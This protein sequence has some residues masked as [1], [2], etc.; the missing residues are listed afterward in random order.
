MRVVPTGV[1]DPGRDAALGR[2]GLLRGIGQSGLL[3]HRQPVHVCAQQH[4]R[5]IAVAHHRNHARPAD[6]LGHLEA[7]I[8]HSR[9]QFRGSFVLF[10]AQFRIGME[11]A[12]ELHQARHVGCQIVAQRIGLR[13]RGDKHRQCRKAGGNRFGHDVGSPCDVKRISYWLAQYRGHHICKAPIGTV[14]ARNSGR[15]S[16]QDAASKTGLAKKRN[17]SRV[18]LTTD[19]SLPARPTIW[20]P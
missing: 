1:H 20:S 16:A 14:R 13:R 7:E 3:D 11:I 17:R 6:L 5:P 19:R 18:A 4:G 8:A 9:R 2:S 10:E 15:K 12:I